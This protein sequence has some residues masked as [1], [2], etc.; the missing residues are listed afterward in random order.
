MQRLGP[1]V[2]RNQKEFSGE[3]ITRGRA[4]NRAA[5]RRDKKGMG[6]GEWRVGDGETERQRDG[7]KER[8]RDES[9]SV[10][11]SLR[12]SVPPS[13]CLHFDRSP[14]WEISSWASPCA[15]PR[16]TGR[17]ISIAEIPRCCSG[18]F[19]RSLAGVG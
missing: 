6:N 13:L 4:Q 5:L 10:S 1:F 11:P 12:L 17:R 15:A 16:M 14:H 3:V 9:L 19:C 2:A 7:E 8:R 18:L